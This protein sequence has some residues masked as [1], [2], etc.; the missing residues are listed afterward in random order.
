[1]KITI[2]DGDQSPEVPPFA[3][4][5]EALET[6]LRTRGHRIDRLALREMDISQC[7]GC[8]GCWVK[9]PGECV[10]KDDGARVCRSVI[11]SDLTV[12]AAPMVLGFPTALLKR[13]VDRLIPL[14]HPYTAVVQGEVHHRARYQRYPTYAL[15]T[16]RGDGDTDE[17][18]DIVAAVFS[19]TA[20][21]FKSK[22]AL[23]R[24]TS[25]PVEEVAH[26][27]GS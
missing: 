1:M 18:L 16:Q 10:M 3:E 24:E 17:D 25:T 21:N 5:M 19:R 4:Y 27:I 15:L 26:A 13:T 14:I 2:L 9:T 11:G 8:W 23:V 12:W 6:M 20:L 7:L 22:L